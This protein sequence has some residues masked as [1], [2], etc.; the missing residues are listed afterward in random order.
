MLADEFVGRAR[1][2]RGRVMRVRK[3]ESVMI[4]IF[5]VVFFFSLFLLVDGMLVWGRESEVIM[6]NDGASAMEWI[7]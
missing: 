5:E 4:C 3:V 7:L 1:R 6:G 2:A